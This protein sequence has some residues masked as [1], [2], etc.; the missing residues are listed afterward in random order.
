MAT[1]P[2]N[3]LIVQS[4]RSIILEADHPRFGEVRDRLMLFAELEKSPEHIHMYRITA[5]SL[6][7]AG[8]SGADAGEI[9]E[10]LEDV[11]KYPVPVNIAKEITEAVNS[12]GRLELI[13]DGRG[14]IVLTADEDELLERRIPPDD[15]GRMV[16]TE[17]RQ[18]C[19]R[20]GIE[21]SGE[22]EPG[23]HDPEFQPHPTDGNR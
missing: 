7:N 6:W 3:P 22:I 12:Y 19:R 23:R 4:D 10:F 1:N 21:M 17:I 11:S 20:H 8:A 5:L 2:E 15:V 9:L 18:V 14:G 13:S 16:M